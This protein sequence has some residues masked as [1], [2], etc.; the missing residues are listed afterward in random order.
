MYVSMGSVSVHGPIACSGAH[1]I[2][3]RLSGVRWRSGQISGMGE[4]HLEVV[5]EKLRSDY[6][7]EA[8][9]GDMR[10]SY[11]ETVQ[12]SA[13]GV[14]IHEVTAGT[15]T[16]FAKVGVKLT[17]SDASLPN[18][19]DALSN[20]NV[21]ASTSSEALLTLEDIATGTSNPWLYVLPRSVN[22]V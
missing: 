19:D 20:N 4:L 5:L 8:M 17:P 10:V 11:R 15:K 13:Q 22:G 9:Y 21:G 3:V 6:K 12:R 2:G 7:V 1:C 18:D 16:H 14:G